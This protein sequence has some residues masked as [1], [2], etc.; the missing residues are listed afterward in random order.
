MKQITA[1][2]T[3]LSLLF[4]GISNLFAQNT[5]RILFI[6][7]SYTYVNNLPQLLRDLALSSGDTI[8]FDSS[9]P[10][11]YTF[12]NHCTNATTLS[13]IAQ[14]NWDYVVLQEQSQKPSFSPQQVASEV[15][16]FAKRLDSLVHVSN[17][18]AQTIFYMTWGRIAGDASNCQFYPPVCTYA[19]MQQ[20]LTESYLLM[21]NNNNAVVAPIGDAWK[22]VRAQ[23]PNINLYSSDGSHPSIEGSYLAA[24]VLYASIFKT[25]CVG[26]S[27]NSSVS[28]S[29]A[30]ILQQIASSTVLD[31]IDY[32]NTNIY[33][34]KASFTYIINGNTINLQS[35]NNNATSYAWSFGDGNVGTGL[36]VNYNYN[37]A[38]AYQILHT[39]TNNCFSNTDTLLVNIDAA[40]IIEASKVCSNKVWYNKNSRRLQINN[41]NCNSLP[42]PYSIIDARGNI[43]SKSVITNNSIDVSHLRA[44][45][46]LLQ[47]NSQVHKFV[48]L[49]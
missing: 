18:C 25:T 1:Y 35:E 30:A 2:L 28:Q 19:G 32:W 33:Y 14:G 36:S 5:K 29:N 11:G 41:E 13:K 48:I 15:L 27:F 8:I 23:Y 37:Q 20:R 42:M 7:N 24:C 40:T 21:A 34:P 31:S 6:G 43:I 38:G 12:Q 16:P 49:D 45:V 9:A 47:Q 26:L 10:G 22:N 3:F 17:T 44:G 46:Y 4:V 39:T